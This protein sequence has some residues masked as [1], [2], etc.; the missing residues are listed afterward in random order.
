[1][2][3]GKDVTHLKKEK[4]V[5]EAYEKLSRRQHSIT[6][7]RNEGLVQALRRTIDKINGSEKKNELAEEIKKAE[8]QLRE[9]ESHVINAVLVPLSAMDLL[10]I[11]SYVAEAIIR[12][13]EASFDGD[14]R[15]FMI[16]KAEQCATVYLALRRTDNPNKRYFDTQEEVALLDE[17][18]LRSI[19][20]QYHEAFSL[21]DSERKN[22]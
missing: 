11:Q 14:V 13:E 8:Q 4:Q 3:D 5:A 2:S 16:V 15:L 10:M 7:N 18:T 9:A 1:M 6:V 21:K 12:A 17:V 19:I 20:E 22:S